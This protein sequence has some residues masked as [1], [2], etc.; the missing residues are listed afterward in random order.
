MRPLSANF[1][2]AT[3]VSLMPGVGLTAEQ[4]VETRASITQY[5]VTWTFSTAVPAGRFVTGDWWVVGPVTVSCISPAPVTERHGSVLNPPAGSQQGYDARIAGFE[6]SLRA[7]F[8]L[9]L[10]AGDSLVSTASV[11]TVGVKTPD[12]VR[13]QYCR[14]PLRTAVVLT[15]P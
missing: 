11:D 9:Q 6:P 10:E 8:P 14:G 5:G 7:V 13:G 2:L 3:L 15:C 4:A 12:T 1:V